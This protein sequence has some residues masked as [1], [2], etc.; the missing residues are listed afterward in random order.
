MW[1]ND[2]GTPIGDSVFRTILTKPFAELDAIADHYI[3][4][5]VDQLISYPWLNA[6]SDNPKEAIVKE[7]PWEHFLNYPPV[8]R[9]NDNGS[10]SFD[11]LA[12]SNMS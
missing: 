2:N 11:S 8:P 5:E 10:N 6:S 9:L 4:K 7:R 12:T 3:H 1:A